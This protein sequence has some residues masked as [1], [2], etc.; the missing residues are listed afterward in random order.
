MVSAASVPAEGNH[1]YSWQFT[2]ADTES[3]GGGW[4][5]GEVSHVSINGGAWQ[6]DDQSRS[7]RFKVHA[8]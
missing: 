7:L 6:E 5:I 1:Y 3:G 2:S 4:T 8:Q